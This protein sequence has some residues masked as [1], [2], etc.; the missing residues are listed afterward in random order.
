MPSA[1]TAAPAVGRPTARELPPPPPRAAGWYHTLFR[2][3]VLDNT[4]ST[5]RDHLALER[6]YL[7][8]VRTSLSLLTF[9]IAVAQFLRLPSSTTGGGGQSNA[10]DALSWQQSATDDRRSSF[11]SA[12]FLLAPQSIRDADALQRLARPIGCAYIV[13]AILVLLFGTVRYYT[14]QADL[15]QTRYTPSAV[16]VCTVS[17]LVGALTVTVLAVVIASPTI[18]FHH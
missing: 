15:I 4:G 2:S 14:V 1:D 5:A 8:F 17:L 10:E 16:E 11:W 6:T 3:Q 13:L 18:A 7:A 9:G 12:G